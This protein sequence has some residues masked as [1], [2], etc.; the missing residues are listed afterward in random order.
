[1]V[2][3]FPDPEA[4]ARRVERDPPPIRK[5]ARDGHSRLLP[6]LQAIADGSLLAVC[7]AALQAALGEAPLVGPIELSL[8][9]GAGI[10]WA[11]RRRW[12]GPMADMVG[13]IALAVL[14]GALTWFLDPAVRVA[15]VGGHTEAA[16]GLHLP[17][18]VGAVAVLRGRTHAA[19]EDDEDQQDRMLRFGIPLLALPWLV[20]HLASEGGAERAFIGTAYISTLMFAASA[21]T[22][23][24]LARLELVRRTS[25]EAAGS[26]RS[27]LLLV[28][29]VALGVTLLGIP[30]AALL[31]VPVASLTAA[32]VGPLRTLLLVLLL[33]STPLIVAVAALTELLGPLLPR[34]I[35]IPRISL[36]RLDTVPADISSTPTIVFF[37]VLALLLVAELLLV[38]LYLWYRMQERRRAA[39]AE[40]AGFEERAIVRPPDEASLPP[41]RPASPRRRFDPAS[42]VGAYLAALE[43]LAARAHLARRASET[44]A[45]HARRVGASIGGP[46]LGRLAAAYQLVRYAGA[47]LATRETR[48]APRRVEEL[49]RR[50]QHG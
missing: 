45:A 5:G 34:G 39:A 35:T 16:L 50:I 10:A 43:E 1:M 27:W 19:R 47:P 20:G 26:R 17:G 42:P 28:G 21:F 30:A 36:P 24:G 14:G 18:W 38:G 15:L 6:V 32:L 48:R 9:A 33:L 40:V 41:A 11:R 46:S 44:P 12:T 23:L 49:R 31:G 2:F 22:A 29:G 3:G 4:V 7:Y 8:F 25:G 13:S 37:A